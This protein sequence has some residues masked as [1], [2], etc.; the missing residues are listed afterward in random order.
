MPNTSY[1]PWYTLEK[2]I[3]LTQKP[4]SYAKSLILLFFENYIL[5]TKAYLFL[6]LGMA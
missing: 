6:S 1:T 5:K 4:V 2:L 3:I